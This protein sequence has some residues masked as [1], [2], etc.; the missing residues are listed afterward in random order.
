MRRGCQDLLD[1]K[2][3]L[4]DLREEMKAAVELLQKHQSR[5]IAQDNRME[6]LDQ[7]IWGI[8]NGRVWKSLETI[9]RLPRTL[10]KR[11]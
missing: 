1:I 7:K 2:T 11:S 8:L 10:F 6:L 5:I 3:E 9:G 4:A